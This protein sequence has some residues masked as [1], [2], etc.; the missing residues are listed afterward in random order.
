MPQLA[1]TPGYL[2]GGLVSPLLSGDQSLL[3][4]HGHQQHHPAQ[5]QQQ[6]QQLQQQQQQS[7]QRSDRIEVSTPSLVSKGCR[8]HS[9]DLQSLSQYQVQSKSK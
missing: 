4:Q 3:G 7:K 6:P 2:A 1:Y 8:E 9:A 5:Q